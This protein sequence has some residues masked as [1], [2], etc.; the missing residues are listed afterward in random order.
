MLDSH[1]CQDCEHRVTARDRAFDDVAVVRRSWNDGDAASERVE[2]LDA[3]RTTHANY[4][5]ASIQ[6]VLHHVVAELSG[7]SDDANFHDVSPPFMRLTETNGI[8]RS[9]TRLSSPCRAA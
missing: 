2:L 4:F 9:R 3:L 5:V 7:G 8:P 1:W 6:S